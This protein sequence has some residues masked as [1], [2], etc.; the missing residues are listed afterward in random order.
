MYRLLPLLIVLLGAAPATEDPL[1]L[2]TLLARDGHW[3]R[4][5]ATLA[6][7][8]P[9]APALDRVR[10]YTLR[11]VVHQ[12]M[13]L[14]DDAAAD[15]EAAIAAAAETGQPAE[16]VLHLRLARSLLGGG[17][18]ADALAVLERGE[19]LF[20]DTI[21][22]LRQ[23]VLLLAELG[24]YQEAVDR[25]AA[26]MARPGASS[27]DVAALAEALRRGGAVE[28]AAIVLGEGRLRFPNEVDLWVQSAVLS[29]AQ[30]RPA[31]AGQFLA[32]A[33]EIDPKYA[34]EA[35]ECYRKAARYDRALALNGLVADGPEKARQRLGILLET[36]RWEHAL[37][38]QPR[39]ERLGLLSDASIA[40]G[41]AYAR[42]VVR[43]HAGSEA[44][45]KQIADPAVYQAANEL[46]LAMAA[47]DADPAACP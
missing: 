39:I 38:L 40:Y 27:S 34:F 24:L 41:L 5:A 10:F 12:N 16:P 8:D 30:D 7:V 31:E 43:D 21:D 35:A 45:L 15:F 36:E 46:R 26:L 13:A 42:F 1:D 19:A 4:A 17:H 3:D 6:E 18:P 2:A 28:R 23:Q 20:P 22:F 11:G 47:C 37:A 9:A 14:H 25:G 44:L 32:V 29:L 33:A